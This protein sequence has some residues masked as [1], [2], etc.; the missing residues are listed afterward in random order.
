MHKAP[1][2][3]SVSPVRVWNH[4]SLEEKKVLYT[5]WK[6]TGLS[7]NRFCKMH[8]LSLDEFHEWCKELDAHRSSNLCELKLTGA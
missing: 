3:V 6:H 7:K 8:N 1:D 4:L 5:Q 2:D